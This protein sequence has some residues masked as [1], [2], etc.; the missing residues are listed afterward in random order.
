[1]SAFVFVVEP[2]VVHDQIAAA[3]E[4]LELLI[5][6]I[7]TQQEKPPWG[8][9]GADFGWGLPLVA[10]P[11]LPP[12]EVHVRRVSPVPYTQAEQRETLQSM[13]GYMRDAGFGGGKR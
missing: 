13:L 8:S 3:P 7:G 2:D 9:L 11:G 1:M 6:T 12:W 4:T 5:A 10:D